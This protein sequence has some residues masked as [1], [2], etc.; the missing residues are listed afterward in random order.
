MYFFAALALTS[1]IMY[2]FPT[3]FLFILTL[4]ISAGIM[5]LLAKILENL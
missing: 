2:M 3:P 5:L 4:W 1:M